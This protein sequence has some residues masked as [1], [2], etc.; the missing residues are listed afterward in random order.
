M[1]PNAHQMTLYLQRNAH[2]VIIRVMAEQVA[3][4]IQDTRAPYRLTLSKEEKYRQLLRDAAEQA[5]PPSLI[6]RPAVHDVRNLPVT[7]GITYLRDEGGKRR[8]Y[9]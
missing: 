3:E 8:G 2:V 1:P 9:R 7:P 5:T 4:E 6:Q